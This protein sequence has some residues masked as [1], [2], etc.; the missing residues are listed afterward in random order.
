MDK[1][2]HTSNKA[3]RYRDIL[4]ASIG[5]VIGYSVATLLYLVKG[6]AIIAIIIA[7]ISSAIAICALFIPSAHFVIQKTLGWFAYWV[8]R[9]LSYI[10]LLPLFYLFFVPARILRDCLGKDPLQLKKT[11]DKKTYWEPREKEELHQY[12]RQF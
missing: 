7:S 8:G 9:L 1:I 4:Q 10:L 11:V 6:H 2:L 12:R 5:L 3:T